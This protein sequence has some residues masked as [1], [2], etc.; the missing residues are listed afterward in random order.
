MLGENLSSRNKTLYENL[1]KKILL[2][3]QILNRNLTL[4]FRE[5]EM[6]L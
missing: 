1:Y 5:V 2:K 6:I 3:F 4:Y